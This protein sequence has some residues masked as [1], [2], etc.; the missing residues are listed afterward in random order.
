MVSNYQQDS[1]SN[2]PAAPGSYSQFENE[3]NN[4][5]NWKST[6][7]TFAVCIRLNY[8]QSPNLHFSAFWHQ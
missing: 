5:N 8:Y 2:A 7:R 1:G 6:P 3:N 4:R